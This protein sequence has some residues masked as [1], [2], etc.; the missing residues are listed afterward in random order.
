MSTSGHVASGHPLATAAGHRM[1][2]AGGNAF[3]AAVAGGFAQTVVEPLL[4]SL[5]GGGCMVTKSIG[6]GHRVYDFF[7]D[8]PGRGFIL[9]PKKLKWIF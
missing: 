3:D 8:F 1:L 4:C 5:G 9:K 2:R 7:V 6:G